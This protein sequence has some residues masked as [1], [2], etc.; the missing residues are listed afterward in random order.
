M[1]ELAA[2]LVTAKTEPERR[3]LQEQ[4]PELVTAELGQ[5]LIRQGNSLKLQGKFSEAL[6]IFQLAER[7]SEQLKDQVGTASALRGIGAVNYQ[8]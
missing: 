6:S 4:E 1:E 2:A 3:G 5:A 8:T 7:I